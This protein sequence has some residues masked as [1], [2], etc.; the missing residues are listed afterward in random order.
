M[1]R[2]TDTDTWNGASVL[3]SCGT[4]P[5]TGTETRNKCLKRLCIFLSFL[6]PFY[7]FKM[8]L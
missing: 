6:Y 8:V 7:N 3:K 5:G 4:G 1:I 2:L